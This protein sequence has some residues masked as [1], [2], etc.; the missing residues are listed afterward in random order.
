MPG[1]VVDE[2]LSEIKA[3]ASPFMFLAVDLP[4]P[5]TISGFCREKH[6]PTSEYIFRP[7]EI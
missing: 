4:P 7:S 1:L 3:A 6:H 2:S 5:S